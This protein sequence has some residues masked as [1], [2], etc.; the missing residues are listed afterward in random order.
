MTRAAA[1][2]GGFALIV[3]AFVAAGKVADTRAGLVA[4]I[5]TLFAG[6]VGVLVLRSGL[7]PKRAHREQLVPSRA[8]ASDN[9]S[10]RSA[11][12]LVVGGGGLLVAAI[13]IA[14]LLWSA[15]WLW[16]LVGGVVL[17][18][19][20]AGCAYLVVLFARARNREWRIDLRRLTSSR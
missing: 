6:L 3:I 14:G 4:E 5:T 1:I 8:R 12:D 20:I 11:N 19:M 10:L 15:G 16:A 13:L 7:V 17:L 2:I 9:E 18:P